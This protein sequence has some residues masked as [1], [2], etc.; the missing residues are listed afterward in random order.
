[1]GRVTRSIRE[2]RGCFTVAC[3]AL[4]L[5]VH[6]VCITAQSFPLFFRFYQ[7]FCWPLGLADVVSR[8]ILQFHCLLL[9]LFDISGSFGGG[10]RRKED[11]GRAVLAPEPGALT[12]ERRRPPFCRR[13]SGRRGAVWETAKVCGKQLR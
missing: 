4:Q 3:A 7:I 10:L 12:N 6:L 9:N 2:G 11:R 8:D 5:V 13:S 1:M